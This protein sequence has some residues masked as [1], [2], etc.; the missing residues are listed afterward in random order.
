MVDYLGHSITLN[1]IQPL[2]SNIDVITAIKPPK[3]IQEIQS[4]VGHAQ[5]YREII[6]NC[7]AIL[8]S[9]TK[10]L[11]KDT[12]FEWKKEQQRA[13]E[14][15][16]KLLSEPPILN[17]FDPNKEI[18][19]FTDASIKGIGAILK[20]PHNGTLKPIA[21][22]S[23]SLQKYQRNYAIPELECYSNYRS[24]PPLAPLLRWK[25]FNNSFRP[26]RSS[27]A[28]QSKTEQIKTSQMGSRIESI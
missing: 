22:F 23:K 19:I 2:K 13:F 27:V 3:N 28:R 8:S 25:I 16:K 21:Y 17:I 20:Q 10:L 15:I 5:Y 24:I 9:F 12:K 6:P 11:K 26:R 14:N 4:F 1:Q 7:T 18:H